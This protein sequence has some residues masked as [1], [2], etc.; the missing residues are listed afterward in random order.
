MKTLIIHLAD[1]TTNELSLI[2]ENCPALGEVERISDWIGDEALNNKIREADNIIMLGHGCPSGLLDITYKSGRSCI[3]DHRHLPLLKGKNVIG[4]WCYA[5]EFAI[6]NQLSGFFSSMWISEE[7]EAWMCDICGFQQEYIRK[8]CAKVATRINRL[9][10]DGV[11]LC[12]FPERLK[13]QNDCHNDLTEFNY[14]GLA[15]F[16]PED[17]PKSPDEH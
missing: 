10:A 4:F 6:D 12:E 15:Y 16:S 5:R 1:E 9:L 2:Y 3:I 11:P 17:F 14:G 8:E 7:I 13:S